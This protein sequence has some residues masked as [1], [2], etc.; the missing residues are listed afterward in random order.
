MAQNEITLLEVW[1]ENEKSLGRKIKINSFLF[2]KVRILYLVGTGDIE[3]ASMV[4]IQ[5]K[6][7]WDFFINCLKDSKSSENQKWIDK[8]TA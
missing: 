8:F 1:R 6:K 2:K 5:N 7:L 3:M 4:A